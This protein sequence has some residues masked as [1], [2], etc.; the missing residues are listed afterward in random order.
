MCSNKRDPRRSLGA[1]GEAL[2]AQALLAAGLTVIERNW[3]CATGEIDIIAEEV[4]PDLMNDWRPAPWRVFI[5]VRTRRGDAFGTALQSITRAKAAKMR[6][7]AAHYVTL[8]DWRGP[9]RIDVVAVQMDARGR[10]LQIKHIRHA[11]TGN[12]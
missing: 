1:A 3:R 10:L 9:W 8:H 2:A 5:E 12:D 11:V 7:T 6:E 4:A